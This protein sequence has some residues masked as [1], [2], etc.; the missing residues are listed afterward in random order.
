[1]SWEH[2]C[3]PKQEGGLGFKAIQVW[4]KA[5]V[6]KHIWFLISGGEQSM[7]CQWVKSYLL[8]G[9]SLWEVKIPSNPSWVWRKILSLRSVVHHHIKVSIGNGK[10]ASLWHDN[11]TNLGS[12]ANRYGT[13]VM[14][15]SGLS[16][17]ATVSVI[18]K[19]ALWAFPITQTLE[20]NEI[21]SSLRSLP[22]PIRGKE[23]QY[24]W[25]LNPSGNF[26]ISS[27]WNHLRTSFPKVFWSK[28]IWFP[29]HIPKCSFITWVAIQHRLYTEDR[30][31]LFGTKSVS[32]CSFCTGSESHDHLFFS[33]PFS[34]QVWNQTLSFLDLKWS[35][36]PWD[37][38]VAHISTIKGKNMKSLITKLAF[39]TTIYHIWIERNA[40]KFQNKV[41]PVSVI[42]SKIHS[43]VRAR[44]L[45]L[46][47]LPV[48]HQSQRLL[49][50]WGIS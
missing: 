32:R 28:W 29:G 33:C 47:R 15:D 12:L 20:L 9:K 10:T 42:V 14:Y 23:D 25:T 1:M 5:A 11:W 34:T 13:R 6:A 8:K 50:R 43:M 2:L 35:P 46:E 40:R 37:N 38:W 31:V 30:L 18:I 21:R 36:R 17:D 7:W 19:D 44:L 41:C 26:T 39:I 4:N 45:S 22:A 49:S 24:I 48:G 27:L 16:K 3:S